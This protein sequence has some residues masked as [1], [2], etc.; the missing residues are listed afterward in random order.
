MPG[1]DRT[2][3]SSE[4]AFAE[5][6]HAP[7]RSTA[8]VTTRN[9]FDAPRERDWLVPGCVLTILLAV[10]TLVTV[11]DH[12]GLMPVLTIL[13]LWLLAASAIAGA[14]GF[15]HMLFSRVKSPFAY[16][17]QVFRSERRSLAIVAVCVIVAGL[18][19]VAFMWV[20]PL[21]NYT[22]PFWA[23]PVLASIDR[24][25]F[26]GHDPWKL[27]SW[28]NAAPAAI[29]YHSGWFALLILTLLIVAKAPPSPDRTAALTC[30]FLLWSVVGPL[31]HTLVP[32]AGPIFFAQMGYGDHFAGLEGVP[33]TR[34]TA[35]YL[36]TN[37]SG[38]NFN[39]G[40]GISAMP[41]MHIATSAWMTICFYLFARRWI[42]AMAA[43]AILMF[44]LSIALGW[45]YA[46]DGV[47]GGASA[48]L[49]YQALRTYY[50][51]TT[52]EGSARASIGLR[53]RTA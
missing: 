15:F 6:G 8:D 42:V 27:F 37:Y 14:C 19:M 2:L 34:S 25:M 49:C 50:R 11:P 5:A 35:A 9:G 13:P 32:A 20:K 22:V 4:S 12:S 16:V 3:G 33:S 41:S 46:A 45:H 51:R 7:I 23:D 21:L 26:L 24:A 1:I 29:F 44:L 47:I 36:W 28:L 18:N 10:F 17:A 52:S 40:T 30:Y 31:I 38:R 43:A 39:P 48:L 53:N